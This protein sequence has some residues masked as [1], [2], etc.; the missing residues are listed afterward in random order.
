MLVLMAIAFGESARAQ[1]P[2]TQEPEMAVEEIVVTATR[3]ADTIQE[4]RRVPGQVYVVT[5]EEIERTKPRT[6]QEAIRQVPGIVLYDQNGNRFQPLVDLRGFNARPN[7]T[8]SF[9]VDGVRVNEPNSTA[10][11]FDLIPIRM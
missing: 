7:P 10:V 11:N 9:F 3:L 6:V 2:P 4:L 5:A 8:T 1:S